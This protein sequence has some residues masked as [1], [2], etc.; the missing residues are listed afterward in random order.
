LRGNDHS[1]EYSKDK[2]DYFLRDTKHAKGASSGVV[3]PSCLVPS[4]ELPS[5]VGCETADHDGAGG[6]QRWPLAGT[7][8]DKDATHSYGC[9][10]PRQICY[11]EKAVKNVFNVFQT[12]YELHQTVYTHK[13]DPWLPLNRVIASTR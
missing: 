11:P 5:H 1:L 8:N 3:S 6:S 13:V 10:Y 4:I 12:R 2:F 9:F 7:L